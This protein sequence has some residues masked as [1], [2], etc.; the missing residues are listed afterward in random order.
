MALQGR[1]PT[2]KAAF[3]E[4]DLETAR[5]NIGG[6]LL[7]STQANDVGGKMKYL[8]AIGLG[9]NMAQMSTEAI[10]YLDKAIALSHATPG[11]PYPSC[12]TSP[13][14]KRL[15]RPGRFKKQGDSSPECWTAHVSGKRRRT[16][17]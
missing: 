11:A 15:R 2:R 10:T 6:A 14:P 9:L 1:G 3:Y 4:G 17:R 5:R 7:A 16:K 12:R 8:Y 13:K